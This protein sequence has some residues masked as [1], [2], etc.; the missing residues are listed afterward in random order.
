MI[1][2]TGLNKSGS[3]ERI[4]SMVVKIYLKNVMYRRKIFTIWIAFLA[5]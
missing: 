3:W 1:D 4:V 5:S 2:T